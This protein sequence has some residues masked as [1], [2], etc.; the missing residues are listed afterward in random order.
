[1]Q[2]A[3][4]LVLFGTLFAPF[5]RGEDVTYE[6]HVVPVFRNHCLSCHNSDRKEAG[7]DLGVYS[8]ILAADVVTS[9]DL[10]DSLLYQLVLQA[11]EPRMPPDQ[12]RIPDESIAVLRQW[13]ESGLIERSGAQAVARKKSEVVALAEAP[14]GRPAGP[15]CLP[16]DTSIAPALLL[17]RAG[18]VRAMASAP[19]APMV[20]VGATGQ[21]C[22][23]HTEERDLDGNARLLAVLPFP[24]GSPM[25]LRFSRTGTLLVAGGGRGGHSG[26]AVVWDVRSGR[27]VQEVGDGLDAVLAVDISPDHRE[28]ALGGAG[29]KVEIYSTETGERLDS[30]TK[31]AEWVTAIEY[32]PD[33][34]LLASADRGGGLYVWESQSRQLFHDL[35]GH[36]AEIPAISWRP[37]SNVLASIGGDGTAHLWNMESGRSSKKWKTHNAGAT[38]IAFGPDGRLVSAGRDK[39]VK[40]WKGDGKGIRG[41]VG[42]GDVATVARF[43]T[44]GRRILAGDFLGG[45]KVFDDS[46]GEVITG[47]DTAIR[48]LDERI[49]TARARV[50]TLTPQRREHE[51]GYSAALAHHT[52]AE[53]RRQEAAER[54]RAAADRIES[55]RVRIDRTRALAEVTSQLVRAT[56]A[57]VGDP[58]FGGT[59][60]ALLEAYR[61]RL[62]EFEGWVATAE[63]KLADAMAEREA[64]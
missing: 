63:S 20:A 29:K 55:E 28:V 32:S 50:E 40:S 53:S 44:S 18:T 9:R 41:F 12:P 39:I 2:R 60:S 34:V 51:A 23:Y 1:M 46:S 47:I 48:P 19:W 57:M 24:E 64:A 4:G 14:S 5:A 16:E 8:A 38:S 6:D 52:A 11:E 10:D 58:E 49:A 27:R 13:I 42:L 30:L 26:R 45:V 36:E 33:G 43:D 56:E 25:T 59:A 35:R 31:H 7:L 22:L 15:P 3:L 21:V 54:K 17:E 61:T 37:D 62:A